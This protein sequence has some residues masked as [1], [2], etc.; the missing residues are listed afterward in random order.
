[1]IIWLK[2]NIKDKLCL[3]IGI[4]VVHL[5]CTYTHAYSRTLEEILKTKEL[6]ICVSAYNG[7]FAV[8]MDQDCKQNCVF[9]GPGIKEVLA[10]VKTL[11][12]DLKIN[13]IPIQ[14]DEQFHNKEGLTVIEDSYT[15]WSLASGKCDFY[16]NHLTRNQWREKKLDF[17]IL[18][19]SNMMVVAHKSL[20]SEIK[21]IQDLAGKS[22]AVDKNTSYHTWLVEQNKTVFKSN[23]MKIRNMITSDSLKEVEAGNIDFTLLDIEVALWETAKRLK[24]STILFSVGQPDEIGW[25]FQKKD[26]DLQKAVQVFF[27]EQRSDKTSDLNKIWKEEY[28]V[29]LIQ[30]KKL[31]NCTN[32]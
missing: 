19:K 15:P 32:Y 22:V 16:P 11:S 1:M 7:S 13:L 25:A 18:Y 21:S 30:L 2:K 4:I 23:P 31:L 27:N 17:I 6:R 28:G 5:L 12:S 24:N 20:K 9:T 3:G 14:W 29:T 10:F 26:K 8:Q